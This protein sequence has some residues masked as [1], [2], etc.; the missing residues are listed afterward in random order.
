MI[1]DCIMFNGEW[2]ALE[3]R[4]RELQDVVQQTFIFEGNVTFRGDPKPIY[5]NGSLMFH[6]VRHVVVDLT[7]PILFGC[8]CCDRIPFTHTSAWRREAHLRNQAQWFIGRDDFAIVTDTDEIPSARVVHSVVSSYSTP[9][10]LMMDNYAYNF[11]WMSPGLAPTG[12]ITAGADIDNCH[13]QRHGIKV[14]FPNAG[15]HLSN[16]GDAEFLKRK[17]QSFSHEEYDKAEYQTEEF[18]R[19]CVEEGKAPFGQYTYVEHPVGL[20]GWIPEK[21][22]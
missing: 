12:F 21:Y 17:L 13:R 6:K 9:T 8:K 1:V 15:W 20:P 3:I 7:D 18:L 10:R 2:D 22:R 16:F 14:G 4:L 5:Y 19:Q 11:H